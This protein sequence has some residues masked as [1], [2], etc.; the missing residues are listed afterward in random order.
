MS[1][2]GK[3]HRGDFLRVYRHDATSALRMVGGLHREVSK[4]Q[5]LWHSVGGCCVLMLWTR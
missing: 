5:E 1:I 3:V 4:W 2:I